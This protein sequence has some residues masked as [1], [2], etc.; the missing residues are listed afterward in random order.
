[1]VWNRSFLY[2]ALLS[3]SLD[4]FA[5]IFS[6]VPLGGIMYLVLY[7]YIP[8]RTNPVYP[9]LPIPQELPFSLQQVGESRY[10]CADRRGWNGARHAF[11]RVGGVPT[12]TPPSPASRPGPCT[13]ITIPVRWT[14]RK[15]ENYNSGYNWDAYAPQPFANWPQSDLQ[16]GCGIA[17]NRRYIILP[18]YT[19]MFY[20]ILFFLLS[21]SFLQDKNLV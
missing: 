6:A 12:S 5:I 4:R 8:H 9:R 1:M 3:S 21:N 15:Y 14:I 2:A 19:W 11:A 10:K 17:A 20:F 7:T 18:Y 13:M 16:F